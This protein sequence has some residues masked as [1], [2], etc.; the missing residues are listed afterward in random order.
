MV[1]QNSN[2]ISEHQS[3]QL[4]LCDSCLVKQIPNPKVSTKIKDLAKNHKKS[5]FDLTRSC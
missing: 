4:Y 5:D 3:S 2:K 1:I